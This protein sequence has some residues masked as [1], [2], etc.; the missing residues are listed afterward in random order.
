MTLKRAQRIDKSGSLRNYIAFSAEDTGRG[1]SS[2]YLKYKLFMPFS[3]ENTH[4]PG[5][6]LG[7]SMVQQSASGLGGTV[8][9]KSSV[10][11]GTLVEVLVPTKQD[12]QEITS[13]QSAVEHDRPL[14]EEHRRLLSGRHCAL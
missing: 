8:S 10:E 6:G 9:V 11:V 12:F 7:L 3:Q 1:V 13:L 4:S 14:Y 5:M 2:E